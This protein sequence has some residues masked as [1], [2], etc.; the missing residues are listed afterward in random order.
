MKFADLQQDIRNTIWK[1]NNYIPV[2]E[3]THA[4][5]EICTKAV[6]ED[7]TLDEDVMYKVHSYLQ[8]P[9]KEFIP[10]QTVDTK[11]VTNNM[12]R[13]AMNEVRNL[14]KEYAKSI[15]PLTP[16]SPPETPPTP[17]S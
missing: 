9:D 5:N 4:A 17:E 15:V 2:Q 12:V 14:V 13:V 16:P 1:L 3:L 10:C 8:R 11:S 7:G 6:E